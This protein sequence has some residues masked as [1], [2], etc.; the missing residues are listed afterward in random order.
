[1]L[2][3]S[4]ALL[5]A[6][7]APSTLGVTIRY[8]PQ[9]NAQPVPGADSVQVAVQV[10]DARSNKA[11]IGTAATALRTWEIT[12]NDNLAQAVRN[13]VQIELQDRGFKIGADSAKLMINLNGLEV[14][15]RTGWIYEN[16]AH[17]LWMM[18]VRVMR[19]NGTVIYTHEAAGEGGDT[20]ITADHSVGSAERVTNL[21]LQDCIQRLFADPKFIDAL[22]KAGKP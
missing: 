4:A 6:G 21:A 13:A 1:L 12:T 9:Y 3:A 8:L 2:F 17:A 19:K 11:D 16:R 10:D 15:R 7:C 5:I 20:S 22:L 14:E 18:Q